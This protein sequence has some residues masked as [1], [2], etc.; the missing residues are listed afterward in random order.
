MYL[1]NGKRSTS[2]LYAYAVPPSG[3]TS[4]GEECEG[5]LFVRFA[6]GVL[7]D[8]PGGDDLGRGVEY[9]TTALASE[10]RFVFVDLGEAVVLDALAARCRL[11]PNANLSVFQVAFSVDGTAFGNTLLNNSG[12]KGSFPHDP[13]LAVDAEIPVQGLYTRFIR[14][15]F[16]ALPYNPMQIDEIDIVAHTSA[17]ADE[18][19]PGRLVFG[20]SFVIWWHCKREWAEGSVRHCD[21]LM[22]DWYGTGPSS[23][24]SDYVDEFGVRYDKPVLNGEQGLTTILYGFRP[25]HAM[26]EDQEAR[27]RW[28]RYTLETFYAH[29][30]WVGTMAYC[31][32]PFAIAGRSLDGTGEAGQY[33]LVNICDLPYDEFVRHVA[34]T[35]ARLVDIHAGRLDPVTKEQLRLE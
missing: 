24:I 16:F 34:E 25:T 1:R 17:G 4:S 10:D 35:N 29:P 28:Y 27:G 8:G 20:S 12:W 31:Y 18:H 26:V 9:P 32:R 22:L 23:M 5:K 3:E 2:G 13:D 30:H 7:M 15:R 21:V 6:D 19:D 14:F 33:G 11:G